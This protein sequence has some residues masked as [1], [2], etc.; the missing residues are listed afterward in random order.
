MSVARALRGVEIVSVDSMAVYREMDLAT[1]KASLADRAEIPHHLIDIL[2]PSDDC[3]VA[4]FQ[5]AALAAIDSVTARG[6]LPL[7]V[8][9]TGLYHRAVIDRLEIPGHYPEIRRRLEDEIGEEGGRERLFERL[10]ASDP[11]AASRVEVANDRRIVR[12]LEVIEGT[13]RPFSSFGPGLETYAPS[14]VLQFGLRTDPSEIDVAIETRVQSWVDG[15]LVD[16]V[17]ALSERPAGISRTARQAIGYREILG[18]VEDGDD[19][20]GAIVA[21]IAR[22]RSFAR[23]QRSWFRRD[24]RVQWLNTPDDAVSAIIEAARSLRDPSGVGH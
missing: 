23:R 11:T 9:G 2:D 7:L 4:L 6:G 19:L 22:T 18:H 12:A 24:P 3:T 16:E 15:G 21:T 1:A 14:T 13:S 8:G 10:K 17:Q 5:A 20:D